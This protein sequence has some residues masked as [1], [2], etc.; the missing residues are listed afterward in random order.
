M[1]SFS[2]MFRPNW[3]INADVW[4][5]LMEQNLIKIISVMTTLRDL[6]GNV[7]D[8][9]NVFGLRY[10]AAAAAELVPRLA[11]TQWCSLCDTQVYTVYPLG[12]V[13]DLRILT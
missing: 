8:N 2:M 6:H 13:K 5:L 12:K 11:N 10:A 4:H 7:H 9:V 3:G 1:L